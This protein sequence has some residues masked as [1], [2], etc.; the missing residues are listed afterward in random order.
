MSQMRGFKPV[1]Y[2]EQ[3][4]SA[5]ILFKMLN[6]HNVRHKKTQPVNNIVVAFTISVW[7]ILEVY[8]V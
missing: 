7:W 8:R 2:L 3:K 4:T 5:N 1:M 6:L